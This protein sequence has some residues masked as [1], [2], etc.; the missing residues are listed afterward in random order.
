MGSYLYAQQQTVGGREAPT[1]PER[2]LNP[3]DFS[4][5]VT[6]DMA[7]ETDT[8]TDNSLASGD[9]RT[10]NQAYQ[11]MSSGS[12]WRDRER[13]HEL[14]LEK[15][16]SA[17]AIGNKLGCSDVTVLDWLDRHG[18]ETRD[19]DPPTMTDGDHPQSVSTE[20]LVEDYQRVAD[21][22][23]K[24][25]SQR[26]YNQH[27]DSYTWSAIRGHFDSIGELQD[28]AGL[29]RLKKDRVNIECEVCGDEFEVKYSVKDDR[30]CCSLECDAKWRE[31][32]YS[33]EEN[34]NYKE[35][36]ESI[37]EWCG[38]TYSAQAYEGGTTRFCSQE[39]MVTWR[40]QKYSGENH[41]RWKDNDDYYRGPNWRRQRERARSRDDY[42][43]QNCGS[44]SGLQVHHIIS[45]ES[46]DDYVEANRLQNLM[47]LCM[48]CHHK[49][50]WGSITVQAELELFSE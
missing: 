27:E 28:A 18:I 24:T 40:G 12:P 26:E 29:E 10:T 19:T 34:H 32:A 8:E 42:E 36:I 37:C 47:T 25:P 7:T 4:I 49:L 45:Y 17:A 9:S 15:E 48:S 30:R 2:D 1:R 35:K 3:E 44:E 41:P 46:F 50:E 11:I 5:N 6:G 23:G 38:E 21:E 14:Y 13:L 20:E 31:E 43:C 22:L 33:G 39:C 16:L